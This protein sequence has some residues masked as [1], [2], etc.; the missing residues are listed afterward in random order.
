MS[1]IILVHRTVTRSDLARKTIPPLMPRTAARCQEEGRRRMM[2]RHWSCHTVNVSKVSRPSRAWYCIDSR[3]VNLGRIAWF[4]LG[5]IVA[6]TMDFDME[7][8]FM[9]I[10]AGLMHNR[11]EG[12]WLMSW[13]S[14][15]LYQIISPSSTKGT[16]HLKLIQKT[17]LEYIMYCIQE[18]RPGR[19]LGSFKKWISK[20]V[21]LSTLLYSV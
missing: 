19:M 1:H 6:K 9:P 14:S 13:S 12:K 16:P 21:S 2:A 8:R 3:R 4:F 5:K 10:S 11:W 7:N 17:G 18:F 15:E 20:D